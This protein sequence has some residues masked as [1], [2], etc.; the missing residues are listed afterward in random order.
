M[1]F[2]TDGCGRAVV[3][4][5]SGQQL[6]L[7][8][9]RERIGKHNGEAVRHSRKQQPPCAYYP[10][11]DSD[12]YTNSNRY[13]YSHAD[14]HSNGNPNSDADSYPYSYSYTHTFSNANP[15]SHSYTHA[16]TDPSDCFTL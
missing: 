3:A 15:D 5:Q 10:I 4:G 6:R 11:H 16:N 13:S 9:V 1:E 14:A 2:G 8:G 7:A 12:P